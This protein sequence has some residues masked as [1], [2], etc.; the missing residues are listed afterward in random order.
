[1]GR[2]K[3]LHIVQLDVEI[4][5]PDDPELNWADGIIQ[6]DKI[7][8]EELGRTIRNGNT[9]RLV[10]FGASLKG[11]IG[12]S[13]VDVG[14]AGTAAVQYCPVTK[15]S[16]G[17][18]QSLQKQWIK[19][20]Q[21]S[22]GVG[23]YVRYDDFEVGW[24][25]FQLLP[26]P[27]NSTILM[28]GLNDANPESVGI[29][30]TSADGAYV[31]LSSYYDNMNPIPEPSEDPFGAVIKT[32]KFS[33]KFPDWRTLI[34]PTTFSSE[35]PNTGG[36]IATG[37]IS[38]L[39]SDNHLSHMTGTLYYFFKGLPGDELLN[40]DDLKLTITLVYEGWASLAKTRSARGVTRQI[41]TTAASSKR[42]TRARRRS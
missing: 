21:L 2:S 5:Q 6:V 37:D 18:W 3:N 4:E 42:T 34:M 12:A 7:L 8:S 19:Q 20:K 15:N 16:V 25:N 26:A 32:A 11:F 36:A 40:A 13:D 27:R 10:G 30:G 23:K 38:W 1:M 9:F 31:S 33:N 35:G 41:P 24:S 14:F 17:A 28:G 22:S 39:P 29:Y